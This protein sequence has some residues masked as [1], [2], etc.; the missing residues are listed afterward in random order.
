MCIVRSMNEEEKA[1]ML[2]HSL[3]SVRCIVMCVESEWM[4]GRLA[5][6]A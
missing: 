1:C 2:T 5:R 4:N 6:S 3:I